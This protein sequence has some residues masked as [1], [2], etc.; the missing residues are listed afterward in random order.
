VTGGAAGNGTAGCRVDR[1]SA[2]FRASGFSGVDMANLAQR[3][4]NAVTLPYTLATGLAAAY[5]ALNALPLVGPLVRAIA[6]A[7]AAAVLLLPRALVR[8]CCCRGE[9]GEPVGE[10]GGAAAVGGE[11]GGAAAVGGEAGGAAAVGGE[12]GGEGGGSSYAHARA[13]GQFGTTAVE[14][15]PARLP[16]YRR[17]LGLGDNLAVFRAVSPHASLYLK[18]PAPTQ[19]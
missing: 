11:A 10:A 4:L 3:L 2:A 17:V 9:P 16:Q 19:A 15:D 5:L 6:A 14:Y 18:A 7:A 8:L 13:S 1:G 12:A